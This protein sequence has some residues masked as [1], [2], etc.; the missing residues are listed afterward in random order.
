M[1][2]LKRLVLLAVILLG[3][4]TASKYVQ[5]DVAPSKPDCAGGFSISDGLG[6]YKLAPVT[7][8]YLNLGVYINLGQYKNRFIL[9]NQESNYFDPV[10][11]YSVVQG[12]AQATVGGKITDTYLAVDRD[13]FNNKGGLSGIFLHST[14]KGDFDGQAYTSDSMTPKNPKEFSAHSYKFIISFDDFLIKDSEHG[15]LIGGKYQEFPTGIYPYAETSHLECNNNGTTC[16]EDII[17][18]PQSISGNYIILMQGKIVYTPSNVG[19]STTYPIYN[20]QQS[21]T[22]TQEHLS[23]WQRFWKWLKSL[24]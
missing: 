14:Y 8:G 17:Y 11:K 20:Q 15:N 3:F 18:V 6:G 12:D 23:V 22:N 5:A 16:A 7:C 1:K 21:A 2:N 24:F 10:L 13:Y 19:Q 9:L 4:N